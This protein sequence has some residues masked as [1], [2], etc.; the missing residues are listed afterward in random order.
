MELLDNREQRM[1]FHKIA[2]VLLLLG[3]CGWANII[4][5]TDF[6]FD[7]PDVSGMLCGTSGFDGCEYRPNG[8]G[9]FFTGSSGIAS[10]GGIFGLDSP[11]NDNRAP[12]G[13]QVAFL[14]FDP[15]N[16]ASSPGNL[17]QNVSGLDPTQSYVVS[18][19]AAQR[20]ETLGPTGNFL[21]GG[22]LDFYV[23]WCPGDSNCSPID[24][25]DFADQLPTYL[26]FAEFTTSFT[27]GATSGELEFQAYDPLGGDRSDFIQGAQLD[28]VPEPSNGL[29]VLSGIGLIGFGLRRK[30]VRLDPDGL[31]SLDRNYWGWR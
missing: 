10:N 14:Q 9:W 25:I 1:R 24:F 2:G 5:P 20:P 18:F 27:A 19:E 13:N 15:S 7:T 31:R 30:L 22:G 4:L 11:G 8:Y 6:S 29:M 21:F 23:Y 16:P 3:C 12:D 28:S 26:S 17:S